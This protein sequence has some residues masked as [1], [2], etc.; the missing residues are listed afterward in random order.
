MNFVIV[1]LLLG[2]CIVGV[3]YWKYTTIVDKYVDR[4]IERARTQPEGSQMSCAISYLSKHHISMTPKISKRLSKD[5][6]T[7]SHHVRL[8]S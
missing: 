1:V 2:V 7:V 6:A 5:L 8:N 3:S 4:A